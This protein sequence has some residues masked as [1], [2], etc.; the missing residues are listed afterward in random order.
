MSHGG[1]GSDVFCEWSLLCNRYSLFK[2]VPMVEFANL[3][4]FT[5]MSLGNH[6]LDDGVEGLLPFIKGKTN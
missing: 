5:A 1:G 3:L 6:E 4:N 2:Y